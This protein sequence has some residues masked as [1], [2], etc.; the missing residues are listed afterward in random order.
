LYTVKEVPDFHIVDK[1]YIYTLNVCATQDLYRQMVEEKN[2]I[3]M[4][5]KL[6]EELEN[7]GE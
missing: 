5:E 2:L 6:I 4:Q 3:D 1:N 7:K